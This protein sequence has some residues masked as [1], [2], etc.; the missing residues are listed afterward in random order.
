MKHLKPI[1]GWLS[2]SNSVSRL[3][4]LGL[5]DLNNYSRVHF[6]LKTGN[7]NALRSRLSLGDEGSIASILE[8]DGQLVLAHVWLV[9]A[10]YDSEHFT[11][12]GFGYSTGKGIELEEVIRLARELKRV[13]LFDQVE[14]LVQ[15]A[16]LGIIRRSENDEGPK[17]V[18]SERT[19]KILP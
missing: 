5:A 11:D 19:G 18:V 13:E 9:P 16:L 4:G 2:E 8:P 14:A 10:G 1:D 3:I 15:E 7:L 17:V 12:A 6:N